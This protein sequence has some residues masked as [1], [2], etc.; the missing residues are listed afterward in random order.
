MN[1]FTYEQ[2]EWL[3]A[4]M[5]RM[6]MLLVE[7]LMVNEL[8]VISIDWDDYSECVWAREATRVGSNTYSADEAATALLCE[9]AR[10]NLEHG[11]ERQFTTYAEAVKLV[12]EFNAPLPEQM[13]CHD[14]GVAN[15]WFATESEDIEAHDIGDGTLEYRV[16]GWNKVRS[17]LQ[18]AEACRDEW[19][20][21]K[22]AQRA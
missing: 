6:E 1:R 15:S 11:C 19:R 3:K 2:R 5:L 4:N 10:F 9:A 18:E 14:R 22:A 8:V 20:K 16:I 7:D 13:Q 17:T 21:Y 12:P